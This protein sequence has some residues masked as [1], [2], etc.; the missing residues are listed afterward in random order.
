MTWFLPLRNVQLSSRGKDFKSKLHQKASNLCA[1][2]WSGDKRYQKSVL[3]RDSQLQGIA[4]DLQ[5]ALS[6]K[7]KAEGKGAT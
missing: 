3:Q 1:K 5:A 7:G 4:R 6:L 2:S